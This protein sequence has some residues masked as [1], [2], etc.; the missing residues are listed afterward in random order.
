MGHVC[1]FAI[2]TLC[3]GDGQMAFRAISVVLLLATL[4]VAGC[5]TVAN[6][7]KP[8]PDGSGKDPFGGVR[9]DLLCIRKAASGEFGF[10]THH[11]SEV[12][13]YPQT[14]LMLFCAMDLP[15]SLIGD[16]LMW[17]YTTAYSVINQPV[18][19]SPVILTDTPVSQP[20]A[21]PTLP[22]IKPMP[23]PIPPK[24]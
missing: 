16:V 19:T 5:G 13:Q 11:K 14:I 20:M 23:I 24:S 22:E 9:H 10:R 3:S 12:E 2:H 15:F 4:P 6:V 1:P 17:P 18:P 7:V 8:R 21:V